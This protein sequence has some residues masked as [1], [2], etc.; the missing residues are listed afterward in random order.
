V[1]RAVR[2]ESAREIATAL[3]ICE[4]TVRKW[5]R[6]YRAEGRDGLRDRFCRPCRSRAATPPPSWHGSSGCADSG[7]RPR[8]SRSDSSW[9]GDRY[10]GA[11]WRGSARSIAPWGTRHEWPHPGDLLHVDVKKLGR[12]GRVGHRSTGDRRRH[13]RGIGD[14]ST[15]QSMQFW[16][17]KTRR[18]RRRS[19]GAPWG[20]SAATAFGCVAWWPI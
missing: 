17:R 15:W 7:G 4:A 5:L 8:I 19:S 6:R 3:E 14:T 9:G 10:R 1:A 12:I 18:R 11:V 2:G 20:G 16:A 13:V